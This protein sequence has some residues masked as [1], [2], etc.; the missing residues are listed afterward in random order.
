[1]ESTE[2]DGIKKE[3]RGRTGEKDEKVHQQRALVHHY[4]MLQLLEGE[5]IGT[6]ELKG[7]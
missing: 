6:L 4:C 5:G 2:E 1:V 3:G 7:V